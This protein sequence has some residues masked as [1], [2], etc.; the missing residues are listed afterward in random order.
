MILEGFVRIEIKNG[1]ILEVSQDDIASIP[2][3]AQTLWHIT[4][5]FKEL[6]FMA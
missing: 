2:K 1:P 5:P 4:A 6:W 3:R